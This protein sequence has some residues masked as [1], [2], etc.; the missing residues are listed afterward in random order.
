MPHFIE[1]VS[2]SEVSRINQRNIGRKTSFLLGKL[3]D[4]GQD[5]SAFLLGETWFPC[6]HV[7]FP[8]VN[9]FQQG[10]I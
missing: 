7:C 3:V 4:I 5:V 6:W 2:T 10:C 1:A 9:R 8:F